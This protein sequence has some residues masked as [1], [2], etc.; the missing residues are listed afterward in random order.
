MSESTETPNAYALLADVTPHRAN[1]E[2]L[3]TLAKMAAR[4]RRMD[5]SPYPTRALHPD[6]HVV[7][8]DA[9]WS[10]GDRVWL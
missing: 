7:P 4:Q 2:A 5:T 10:V 8:A 9:S 3:G 1:C 6:C